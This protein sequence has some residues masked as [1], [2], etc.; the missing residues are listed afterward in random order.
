MPLTKQESLLNA[1]NGCSH[2]SACAYIG[3]NA[4]IF[5]ESR[6][7]RISTCA[8]MCGN[9]VATELCAMTAVTEFDTITPE[10]SGHPLPL[11]QCIKRVVDY[12]ARR[13]MIQCCIPRSILGYKLPL[14]HGYIPKLET[15]PQ[16][17]TIEDME[18]S[19]KNIVG[20]PRPLSSG[21]VAMWHCWLSTVNTLISVRR[22][23]SD[24]TERSKTGCYAH[25][26]SREVRCFL[27]RYVQTSRSHHRRDYTNRGREHLYHRYI[28]RGGEETRWDLQRCHSQ[29]R[30]RT[31]SIS[32]SQKRIDRVFQRILSTL[33]GTVTRRVSN[34]GPRRYVSTIYY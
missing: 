3:M 26:T 31:A 1:Q 12:A 9:T 22:S 13:K 28:D 29:C 14:Y 27:Y 5:G 34:S 7:S 11:V 17:F 33:V 6:F 2:I 18:L 8:F 23:P 16:V 20:P 4:L 25:G 30:S 21:D 32:Y 15:G 19:Q 10:I 24:W